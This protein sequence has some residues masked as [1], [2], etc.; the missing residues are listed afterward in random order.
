MCNIFSELNKNFT[1]PVIKLNVCLQ[2]IM[3]KDKQIA[4]YTQCTL[5]IK[6]TFEDKFIN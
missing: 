1:F 6:I 2:A 3:L 5:S 4:N